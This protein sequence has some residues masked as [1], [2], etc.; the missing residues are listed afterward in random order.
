MATPEVTQ[1]LIAWGNGDEGALA[2]L[3]PLVQVELNRLAHRYLSRER[4]GHTLQTMDL[5]N[6]A[7]LRL[8]DSKSLHW[9][10]RAHFFGI[11]SSVMRRILVDHARHRKELKHGGGAIQ[12]SLTA[13]EQVAR[14]R[15]AD[16]LAL[17]E[18][19]NQLAT[20]DARKSQ[21]IELRFF[22]GLSET[23][24][25]EVLKISLRTLQREWS[26]ARAWLYQELKI[27]ETS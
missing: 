24:A 20:F 16:V 3:A 5:V 11:A 10:S 21:I 9:Q 6:E 2:R 17:D 18:A 14:E 26:L 22:G 19:L 1:L 4:P 8:I 13:A 27:G 25:A 15:G 7:Y 23:E 12:V